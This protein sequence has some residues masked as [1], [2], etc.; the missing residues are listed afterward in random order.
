MVEGKRKDGTVFP[1]RLSISVLTVGEETF[2]CGLLEELE[3]AR[4]LTVSPSPPP[5]STS[6][7]LQDRSCLVTINTEGIILTVNDKITSLFGYSMVTRP[8]P[9][10]WLD[11]GKTN[12]PL[13]LF[14]RAG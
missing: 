8:S 9:S 7:P 13:F 1:L 2:Y 3:V 11:A 12:A 14:L 5:L 10:G 4:A 6:H